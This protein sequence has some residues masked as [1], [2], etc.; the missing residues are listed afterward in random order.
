MPDPI[1]KWAGGK[2]QILSEIRG[3][4]P[5]EPK[6]NS[7]HEPFFGGGAIFF[8]ETHKYAATINDI[9]KRL[10]NFYWVVREHP[11]KL[12]KENSE[13][14]PDEEYYY[15][16]RD[17]FNSLREG[18][19]DF[20]EGLKSRVKEA[21]LLLYLNRNCFN[22]LYRENSSGEFNVPY[23]DY[24][25][26]DY[27]QESRIREASEAL[28]G[29]KIFNRDFQ[30]ILEE[31]KEDDLVYFDPP[32]KPVERS[33]S[34]VEYHNS[35]FGQEEQ[36][37]LADTAVELNKKGVYV[38]ISN[39]PA[40][41]ELYEGLEEFEIKPVGARRSINSNADERGEVKEVILTNVSNCRIEHPDLAEFA[42]EA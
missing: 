4:F 24:T 9:N 21:S 36:Q 28:K 22:G 26:P 11:E 27:I 7:Y 41:E 25:N 10:M 38:V 12:I 31:A 8:R 33:S 14:D 18:S 23:G 5:P 20:E 13:H 3:S 42:Q 16:A 2:R 32:Y 15:N 17:R 1:L 37:R 29:T 6:I 30:Y 34:F 40:M 39:S 35:T 19:E